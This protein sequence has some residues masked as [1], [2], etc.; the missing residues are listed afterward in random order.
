MCDTRSRVPLL[1]SRRWIRYQGYVVA[2][3]APTSLRVGAVRLFSLR[4]GLN[5][6]NG[7]HCILYNCRRIPEGCEVEPLAMGPVLAKM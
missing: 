7:S 3:V 1:P 6:L 4:S 2:G 5:D